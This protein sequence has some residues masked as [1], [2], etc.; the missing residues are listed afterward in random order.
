MLMVL[1]RLMVAVKDNLPSV[2]MALAVVFGIIFLLQIA[3]AMLSK[4]A[5]TI[6]VSH[7]TYMTTVALLSA[8]AG[9][10][11]LFEFPLPFIAPGFY[12]IDLSEV[13]IIIG[14][15]TLGPVAGVLIEFIKIV[16]N[17]F[18]NGT[19]TAFI[20]EMA[21]FLMGIAF[22]I[23]ASMMYYVRKTKRR[24]VI[25]LIYG[26]VF[27]TIIGVLL[28]A[29]VL[30]PFYAA[31]FGG[32]EKIVAAGTAVNP[33]I[34]SVFTFCMIAV[35]PFNLIKFSVVSVIAASIY[36]SVSRVIKK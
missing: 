33:A 6:K 27:A 11:M 9:I 20:G 23:P 12:K 19:T 21:N 3:E 36:G 1:S 29:Y 31:A 26:A 18:V 13:P 14:A 10:L 28:N 22:V 7:V 5:K 30:L 17:L 24:A 32:I 8:I 2:M 25:G 35:A 34:H 15:F 16:I 4:K